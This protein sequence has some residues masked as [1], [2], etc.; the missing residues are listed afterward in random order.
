MTL[1]PLHVTGGAIAILSGLVALYALKGA[2]LHRTSGTIFV[3]AILVMSLSGVVMAVGRAGAAMNIPA[4]LV[5]AYLV[6]TSLLTVHPLSTGT[7][8]AERGAM[9]AA[10]AL[11]LGSVLAAFVSAGRGN[12]GFVFP[13]LLFSILA[14]SAGMGDRRML[15]AGGLQ[16]PARLRRHLWRMCVALFIAAASF[17]LGPVR[18]IPEPLRI[19]VLRLIPLVVLVTMVYWLWRYR[20]K[21][22]S[23]SAVDAAA[24]EAI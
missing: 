20:R 23:P 16:G 13:L 2:Q 19:P 14:F 4:G 17:F 5:T 22:I 8:R 6:I 21:R 10:F 18:R 1:V 7:R 12:T 11:G 9:L 15:R 3:Y 24:P